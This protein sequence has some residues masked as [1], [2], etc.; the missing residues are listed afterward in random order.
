[1][2]VCSC[3]WATDR[4]LIFKG[5]VASSPLFE[6][7]TEDD[8][9]SA[10]GEKDASRERLGISRSGGR[11]SLVGMDKCHTSIPDM[12]QARNSVSAAFTSHSDRSRPVS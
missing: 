5:G 2:A 3:F 6:A 7:D 11:N 10:A 8:V 9:G 12:H 1:M 4:A